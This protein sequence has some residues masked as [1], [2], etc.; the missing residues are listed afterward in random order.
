MKSP[1]ITLT[2][3]LALSATISTGCATRSEVAAIRTDVMEARRS[4]DRALTI[5]EESN[6]RSERT[7][8]MINRS[9]RLGMRK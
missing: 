2:F 3:A 9:F 8:E 5:A 7:E 6:R 1:S 4:A